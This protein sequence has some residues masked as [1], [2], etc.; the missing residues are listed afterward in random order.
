MSVRLEAIRLRTGLRILA[1]AAVVAAAA[2]L[3]GTPP[4][5]GTPVRGFRSPG[6][7]PEGVAWDGTYIWVNDFT[8]GTLAAVDP[9]DGHLV[10]R[11]DLSWLPANPEGLASD[12]ENLWTVDWQPPGAI[13]KLRVTPQGVLWLGSWPKPAESGP[14]VGLEWDGTHLWLATW[15]SEV[16]PLGQLWQLDP[17]TLQPL[18]MVRTPIAHIEDLAWDGRWFWSADWFTGHGFAIDPAT[19]DTLHTY[20]TPGPNPVGQAWDGRYLWISDTTS[21]SLW[22]LDVSAAQVDAVRAVSWGEAKRAYAGG[23]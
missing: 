22:A 6:D 10:Q 17:V 4:R 20:R 15:G 13:Y 18:R 5:L 11:L 2:D 1:A 16:H 7:Y 19:G 12:G 23:E 14:A 8:D 3:S 9:A 21:D